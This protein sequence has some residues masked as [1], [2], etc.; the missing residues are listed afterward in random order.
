[1]QIKTFFGLASVLVTLLQ[2]APY[3]YDIFRRKT[4][5][6]AFSWFVWGLPC[7]IVFAAQ[8]AE[9]G[10]AGAWATGFTTIACTGIFILALFYGDRNIHLIDWI[11][12]GLASL[13]IAVWSV[14]SNPLYAVCLITLSDVLGFGPTLRK[15]LL[16]PEEE[17][18]SSY[19]IAGI[20]WILALLAFNKVSLVLW[21]Y[22]VSMIIAN[23]ILVVILM[24]KYTNKTLRLQSRLN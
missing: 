6:H 20:K 7:F 9:G 1:M 3:I 12:L 21:L 19:F 18:L 4:Y 2:F 11:C 14:T 23:W 8:I 15:S 17:T 5:P 13:A 10:A 24:R 22:P 16:K